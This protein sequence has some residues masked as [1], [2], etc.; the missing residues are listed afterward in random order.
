MKPRQLRTV[1]YAAPD[2]QKTRDW[3]VQA[4]EQ[5]PYFDEP[6]YVG[7]DINGYELGLDPD[8]PVPTGSSSVAYWEVDDVR[9]AFAQLLALGATEDESIRDVGGGIELGVVKDPFGNR[10]GVIQMG[11][12]EHA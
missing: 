11:N 12:E 3:Y 1:I 8:M 4:F 9:A 10:I 6:F 7:F 5:S 2:I